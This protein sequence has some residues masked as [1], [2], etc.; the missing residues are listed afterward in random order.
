M[1]KSTGQL[2]KFL[3]LALIASACATMVPPKGGPRDEDPPEVVETEPPNKSVTFEPQEV[4][5]TFNE[6]V[7]LSDIR[8]QVLI[9]PPVED[10]PVFQLRGKSLQFEVPED[11]RDNTTYNIYFGSSIKDITEGNEIDNYTY[12]FS[13]GPYL[14][15]LYLSGRAN[16]ALSEE[17][18]AGWIIMLYKEKADSVPMKK[19]PYYITK[20]DE[21]GYFKLENLAPGN[22]KLFGLIDQNRNY[23]YDPGNESIAFSDTLVEPSKPVK[24]P[25][26]IRNDSL[27]LDSV[28]IDSIRR[29]FE[30]QNIHLR[31]FDEVDTTQRL[32]E[33]QAINPFVYQFV[34]NHPT[35]QI[36]IQPDIST[37]FEEKLNSDGDTLTLYFEEAIRDSLFCVLSD[38]YYSWNDSIWLRPAEKPNKQRLINSNVSDGKLPFYQDITFSSKIPFDNF[39]NEKIY[40]MEK[41]DSLIDTIPLQFQYRDNSLKTKLISSS[42]KW[43]SEK[44]YSIN[45]YPKAF[46]LANGFQ[47]DSLKYNFQ[48]TPVENY[49]NI[50]FHLKNISANTN[51]IVQLTDADNN[52]LR[53]TQ[54]INQKTINFN[55]LKPQS[56]RIRVIEDRNNNGQWDTGV[57]LKKLQPEKSWFFHKN[58]NVRANWDI[59]ETMNLEETNKN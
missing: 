55:N 9:S 18:E 49:G 13:T 30:P 12:T 40:I 7:K 37:D 6:F 36:N 10:K 53:E 25:D 23:M 59:E 43:N 42:Y 1:N 16:K 47:N 35:R 57:Y 28:N 39:Q 44:E 33:A 17:T 29:K 24:L 32:S 11:L 50:I 19:V 8:N 58:F 48:I 4:E 5:I 51:Y 26:S 41:K 46:S 21:N 2:I 27:L 34:F 31:F 56:Y 52:V 54:V 45:I 3:F 22:Y 38:N 15:S 20:T 14:D